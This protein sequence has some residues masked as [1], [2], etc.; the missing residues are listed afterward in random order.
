MIKCMCRANIY[1]TRFPKKLGAIKVCA[2]D[3]WKHVLFLR[4]LEI[5]DLWG[6]LRNR[7]RFPPINHDYSRNWV[8]NLEFFILTQSL[9]KSHVEITYKIKYFPTT[10]HNLREMSNK[11]AWKVFRLA[12]EFFL[13]EFLLDYEV[14]P[15]MSNF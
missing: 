10:F 14:L 8:L 13:I 6:K 7:T 3:L 11:W 5:C 12:F 1:L 9:S 2:S 15:K 4:K